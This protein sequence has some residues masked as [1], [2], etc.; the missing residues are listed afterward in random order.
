MNPLTYPASASAAVAASIAASASIPTTDSAPAPTS[1]PALAAPVAISEDFGTNAALVV[2]HVDVHLGGKLILN[3]VSFHVA[4]GEFIGILGPNGAGKTTLFRALLG[5]TKPQ[6]GSIV[7]P[8][9]VEAGH[10]AIGYVPQFRQ[11]DPELP[12]HA[13]DFVGL[14]LPHPIRPWMNRADRAAV[15]AALELTGAA[16]LART[17]I[18]RLSGGERQRIFLAQALVRNPQLLLL[19]EP[20]SNLD[21][22]AQEE[23]A[24]VVD[25]IRRERNIAVLLISHDVNLVNRYADRILYLT[26]RQHAVGTVD[27]VMQTSVLRR[28]YGD[29]VDVLRV[30]GKLFVT[31]SGSESVSDI[32]GHEPAMPLTKGG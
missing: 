17:S 10:R 5:L 23:I 27:E 29:A 16:H 24:A 2:R 20:T 3:D 1:A 21:P 13:R 12:M 30:D 32:C 25:R 15:Q 14:G 22:G 9:P 31:V 8:R 26:P 19:D 4:A 28:L 18:G 11:I 7:F 6:S